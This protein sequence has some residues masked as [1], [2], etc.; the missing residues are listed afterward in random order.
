[1][2]HPLPPQYLEAEILAFPFS[3][4]DAFQSPIFSLTSTDHLTLDTP[5]SS[6]A[7]RLEQHLRLRAAGLSLDSIRTLRDSIWFE[8]RPQS[9]S[10]AQLL[11]RTANHTLEPQGARVSLHYTGAC[12]TPSIDRVSHFRWLS[13]AIPDDLLIAARYAPLS[14]DPPADLVDASSPLLHQLLNEAPLA[15]LHLHLGAAFSFSLLWTSLMASISHEPPSFKAKHS[16]PLP[17]FAQLLACTALSRILMAAFLWRFQRSTTCPPFHDFLTLPNGLHSIVERMNWPWGTTNA[18]Q[19]IHTALS[20]LNGGPGNTSMPRLCSLLRHLQGPR[21]TSPLS[22][23]RD[24][25]VR[26]PLAGWLHPI[27]PGASPE[28]RFAQH[29]IAYLLRHEQDRA[30]AALFW[31][32]TRLRNI[33]FRWLTQ[34]RG[35]AGLDWFSVHYDR[36]KAIRNKDLLQPIRL[37]AAL[38][39]E[40]NDLRLGAL[41]ARSAPESDWV[42][43]RD[44]ARQIA[45][46]AFRFEPKPGKPKPEVGLILHFI[47]EPCHPDTKIP[48][49]DPRLFAHR[50]RFGAYAYQKLRETKAIETALRNHPELLLILRGIDVASTELSIPTWTLLPM[51]DRLRK[52]SLHASSHLAHTHPRAGIPPFRVTCH[53]GEDFRTH[54]EGLR[55]IH[56]W[57]EFGALREGDRI[58][59]ALALGE[60][61]EFWAHEHPT[62]VQPAEERLDDLLWELDRYGRGCFPVD[63]ARLEWIRREALKHA[64]GI[65]GDD[66]WTTD[67]LIEARRLRH[68]ISFLERLG[69]PFLNSLSYE[70][71]A[72]GLAY[73]YLTDGSVYV[74]GQQAVHIQAGPHETAMLMQAQSWLATQ[75]NRMEM[76]VESNP[77]SNMLIGDMHSMERHPS[78]RMQPVGIASAAGQGLQPR[79]ILSINDD[80]PLTFA[81][82]LGRE[83]VYM[84]SAIIRAGAKSEDALNWLRARRDDGYRARFTLPASAL[85]E[86]L[87]KVCPEIGA[88]VPK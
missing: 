18:H 34:E 1:M 70:K 50:M 17:D 61:P 55:R 46:S 72:C 65:Y 62:L 49:A 2:P 64:R 32:Y 57:I 5:T 26:D 22:C 87:D 7:Q 82:S 76:S 33:T 35:T 20:S 41:E 63:G 54:V 86:Y 84:Y 51:F 38:E 67:L 71:G 74:R 73:R 31:Q 10:L 77:S 80:D 48:H 37:D 30:F 9:V 85:R 25:V 12:S 24:L 6:L 78:L 3:S 8:Q 59:H 13:L 79:V 47:K 56:E 58:G 23:P 88:T 39:L 45:K 75:L 68:D 66:H 60:H 53:A 14:C 19:L 16:P 15:N 11:V 83:Y 40:S 28:T 27:H 69:Y 21:N 44:E 42:K 52:A 43:I 36:I 29:A 81:T 4:V